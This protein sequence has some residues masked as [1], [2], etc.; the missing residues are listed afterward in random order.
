MVRIGMIAAVALA[1][2]LA[3]CKQA[4][5]APAPDTATTPAVA[6]GPAKPAAFGQ[7]AACHSVEPGMNGVGPSLAGV[8]GR[9]AGTIAGFSYGAAM[10]AYGKTWDEATLDTYLTSP[11]KTVPG[12]RM[13]YVGQSDPAQRKAVIEYL[14]TLK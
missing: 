14:K 5:V 10:K 9:K 7:C 2:A 11:A 8:V 3:G 4:P 12:T 6:A 13:T 1:A